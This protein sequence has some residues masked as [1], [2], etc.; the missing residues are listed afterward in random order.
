MCEEGDLRGGKIQALR[1][2]RVDDEFGEAVLSASFVFLGDGSEDPGGFDAFEDMPEAD[3][4]G[5]IN[6]LLLTGDG[7]GF[8][9]GK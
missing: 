2:L 4:Q 5:L 6:R 7:S 1:R 9:K 3:L 8:L